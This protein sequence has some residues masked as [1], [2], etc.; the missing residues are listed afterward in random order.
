MEALLTAHDELGDT[1]CYIHVPRSVDEALS[2]R[3]RAATIDLEFALAKRDYIHGF[4]RDPEY[5]E[6]IAS[7]DAAVQRCYEM[8]SMAKPHAYDD[9]VKQMRVLKRKWNAD[10]PTFPM[11]SSPSPYG[12]YDRDEEGGEEL[13]F[14]DVIERKCSP[15]DEEGD[16]ELK[17]DEELEGEDLV[18]VCVQLIHTLAIGHI[19]QFRDGK[20]KIEFEHGGVGVSDKRREEFFLIEPVKRDFFLIVKGALQGLSGFVIGCDKEARIV[21]INDDPH[22]HTVNK[23]QLAKVYDKTGPS[24]YEEW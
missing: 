1:R 13:K 4:S 15:F 11:Q 20:Y 3:Q 24:S 9:I 14:D 6:L 2:L 5:H 16:E 12:P 19:D 17:G 10:V 22:V 18:G 21:K 23:S 8:V 7:C